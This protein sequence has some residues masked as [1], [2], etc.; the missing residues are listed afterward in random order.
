MEYEAIIGME[1]HVQLKTASKIYCGCSTAFGAEPNTQTCPVCLGLPGAL[2]VLNR[3]A[4]ELGLKAAVTLVC[5]E[6]VE[7]AAFARKNYFYPDLPKG[8]QITQFGAPLAR[9]GRIEI[10]VEGQQ[11]EIGIRHLLIEEDA[12]KLIHSEGESDVSF[13]DFNRCG[14][15]LLEIVSEP[16]LRT[17][18]EAHA[19]LAA[20]KEVI[21]YA[22]IS[23]ADMEKGQMRC[24]PNI[25]VRPRGYKEFGTRT[26]LKN[27]N[28]FRNVERAIAFEIE[29]HIG[30]LERGEKVEQATMLWDERAQ[31]ASPMRVKEEA[32]DYRYFP[33][34]DL[35]AVTLGRDLA[36][37]IRAELPELP[38]AKRARF[39]SGYG[40]APE[41]AAVCASSPAVADYFEAVAKA[42]GDG[43]EAA[44]WIVGVVAS[45]VNEGKWDVNAPSVAAEKLAA[46]IRLVADGAVSGIAARENVFPAM[47]ERP[48]LEPEEA[49][50]ELGLRQMSD[51]ARLEAVVDRV[52]AA[53]PGEVVRY[54]RGEEKLL[55]YFV[56][57]VMEET[58]GRANPKI[59]NQL[60]RRKL[61]SG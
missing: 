35:T 49:V 33:E 13:V 14:V 8:Y 30:I 15:P 57:Q 29:R 50:D 10:E 58:K 56:G 42:C 9:H 37:Q 46:L 21:E 39:V 23:D 34:P 5:D 3:K 2:P 22:G 45:A 53:N 16:D 59:V 24:E 19:Y 1:V 51:E 41:Q 18:A 38:R 43:N 55:G 11:K 27:L 26:E 20:L 44:K 32:H 52:I 54:R 28:S 25:S 60:L 31:R 7:R 6:I 36:A 40:I 12:G 4:V 61:A 47:L 17:P 48:G